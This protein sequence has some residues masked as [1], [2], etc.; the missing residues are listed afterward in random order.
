MEI[1]L[2]QVVSIAQRSIVCKRAGLRRRTWDAVHDRIVRVS[3]K[4]CIMFR[5]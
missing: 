1:R 4:I 3:G 2:L 5:N